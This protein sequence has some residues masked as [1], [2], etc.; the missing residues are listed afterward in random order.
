MCFYSKPD[1]IQLEREIVFFVLFFLIVS[2]FCIK[3]NKQKAP[4]IFSVRLHWK[5][6]LN[7][8][9]VEASWKLGQ[10]D[11]LEDYLSSGN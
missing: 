8:Y 1:F 6:E 11:L 5:S 7:T 9:R 10:W 3:K 2:R 4:H